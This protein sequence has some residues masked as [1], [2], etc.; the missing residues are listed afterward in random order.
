MTG[1]TVIR[2]FGV[3]G[4]RQLADKFQIGLQTVSRILA[5]KKTYLLLGMKT[6]YYGASKHCTGPGIP[7]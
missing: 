1:S 6:P 4:Q 2:E 5:K 7:L 3:M